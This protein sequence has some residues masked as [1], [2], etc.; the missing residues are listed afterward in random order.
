MPKDTFHNL[1]DEKKRRIFDAAV[2]EFST[3]RF[4]EASI[5][6][7]VKAAG[8]P[9]GSFYQYFDGKED[10]Y[11]YMRN[12]MMNELQQLIGR[13]EILDPDVDALETFVH[14]AIAACE[15]AKTR[16]EYNRISL[17]MEKD[18]SEFMARLREISRDDFRQVKAMFERDKRSGLIKPD[19]DTDLVIDMIYAITLKEYF[20]T[21]L[22][23]DLFLSRVREIVKIVREGISGA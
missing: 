13:A 3:R 2:Q 1:S 5:N 22:D 8:I 9:R 16:P 20:R 12:E 15:L 18:D 6:Q 4:S 23:V 14:K 11:L 10:I 21:G 19:I 17:L 7:I